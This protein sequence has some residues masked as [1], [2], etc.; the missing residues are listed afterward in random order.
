M[1][2]Q[3]EAL[4]IDIADRYTVGKQL[5]FDLP[6]LEDAEAML[7]AEKPAEWWGGTQ[8]VYEWALRA[9]DEI[10]ECKNYMAGNVHDLH[11]LIPS[12]N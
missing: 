10:L 2:Q 8:D 9:L 6:S 1:E 12:A 11:E 4:V 7:T 5:P 3:R